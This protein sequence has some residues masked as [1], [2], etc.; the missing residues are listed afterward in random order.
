MHNLDENSSEGDSENVYVGSIN[1]KKTEINDNEC[2]VTMDVNGNQVKYKIDTGA[3]CNII[4]KKVF[5]KVKASTTVLKKS[6]SRLTSYMGDRLTVLRKTTLNCMGHDLQ[7]YVTDSRQTSLLGFKASQDL[8][9]IEVVLAV[10]TNDLD[11]LKREHPKV[12]SGLGCLEKPYKIMIDPTVTPV[13]NAPGKVPVALRKRVKKAFM[14]WKMM[15]RKVDEPTDWVN[16]MVI[17]EKTNKKLRICL[18][19]RSLNTAIKRKHFQLPTIEEITSRM[20]G[21]KIFSKLDGN[22]SYWQLKLDPE[23]Q[24]LTTFNTPYG[25]YYYLRTPSGIKSAQEMYQKRISQLF[26]DIEGVETDIDDILIWGRSKEEHDQH[27]KMALKRCEDIGLTLNE[28]KCVQTWIRNARSRHAFE[29][30]HQ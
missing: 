13:V 16:S 18:D 6:T 8:G 17:V 3:Q 2:F 11:R 1:D 25:R 10:N 26:E 7:F 23:S 22:N 12:F 20:S 30:I 14:T 29:S 21:A 15:V 19:P 24:L 5:E 28:D 4:T 27:L 9:L